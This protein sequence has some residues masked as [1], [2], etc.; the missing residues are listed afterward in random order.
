MRKAIIDLGTNTFNLLIAEVKKDALI[1]VHSSKFAVH[2]GMGGIN[3]GIISDHALER[4]KNA[5]QE[6]SIIC[7]KMKIEEI[8][9]IG[10]AALRSAKNRNVL[11]DYAQAEL[12]IQIKTISG[13]MEA[14][15]IY[16][17]VKWTFPFKHRSL[18]MDIGGGST[19]FIE[20]DID[21]IC[22]MSSMDIGVSRIFQQLENPDE[23]SKLHIESIYDFLES[24]ENDFFSGVKAD[25]MIGSSGSFETLYEVIFEKRF[26]VLAHAVALPV[27]LLMDQLD[28]LIKA[29]LEERINNKW[30]V[31]MRKKMIP[32]SAIQVKWVIEKLG[33]KKVYVSPFSLK[34]GVFSKGL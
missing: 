2:L 11:I 12:G 22:S 20:A 24:N 33:I 16:H 3:E 5:L 19:E 13:I 8:Q 30:I 18:I 7:S 14:E 34:E 23:Y 15:L 4:A 27:N 21:G 25:I 32:I 17:G 6:F 1:I 28:W 10:T 31:T 29:T 26:P 9:G